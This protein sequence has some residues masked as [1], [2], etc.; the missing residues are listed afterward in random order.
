M[1]LGEWLHRQLVVY[2]RHGAMTGA[3]I[4]LPYPNV[5]FWWERPDVR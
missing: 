3:R 5:Q 4:T 1:L 2:V